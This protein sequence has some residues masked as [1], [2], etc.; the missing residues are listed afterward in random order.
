MSGEFSCI[1]SNGASTVDYTIMSTEF[2]DRIMKYSIGDHD[3]F[4]HLPQSV[5]VA[6]VSDCI[7]SCS[8]Y[9]SEKTNTSRKRSNFKWTNES[10]EKLV[11]SDF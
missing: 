9:H 10:L 7:N 1:T 11:N 2:F 8:K 5:E 4:T 3:Q 6:I